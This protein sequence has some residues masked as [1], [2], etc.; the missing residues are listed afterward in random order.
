MPALYFGYSR[1][2]GPYCGDI[3]FHAAAPVTAHGFCR[4]AHLFKVKGTS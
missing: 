2:K 1:E 3:S 4:N